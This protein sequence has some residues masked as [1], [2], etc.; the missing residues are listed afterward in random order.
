[1]PAVSLP[2]EREVRGVVPGEGFHDQFQAVP[3]RAHHVRQCLVSKRFRGEHDRPLAAFGDIV[4]VDVESELSDRAGRAREMRLDVH[5][6]HVAVL[7]KRQRK[8]A[9]RPRTVAVAEVVAE[10]LVQFEYGAHGGSSVSYKSSTRRLQ[11][12]RDTQGMMLLPL[13]LSASDRK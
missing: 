2:G 5:R 13:A 6:I 8:P 4:L 7:G 10:G 3:L 9:N 12:A 1:M 11:R